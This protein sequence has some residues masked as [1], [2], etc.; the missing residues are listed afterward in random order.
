MAEMDLIPDDFRQGLKKRRLLHNFIT[1]CALVLC[2]VGLV[3][4]LLTYLIWRDKVEV[5]RLEQQESISEQNKA[6]SAEYRQRKEVVQ[7]Q[8]AALD[9]LRGRDRV[10]LFLRAIDAAHSEGIWFDS[11]HFL[12]RSATGTL[13]N[14]PGAAHSGII[15][16]A[17]DAAAAQPLDVSQGVDI[18]GHA[19]N[20]T[21]LADF[22]RKLG[23]Q[24]GVADLRLIDTN[25]RSYTT[26]QVID[27]SLSL[28]LDKKTAARP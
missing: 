6:K 23:E 15:V 3:W 28:Q 12:R 18:V 8:L 4:L 25:L 9:E 7:Q 5:A 10:A 14:V 26:M 24:P 16:A 27:F 19:L 20:H 21:L 11:V 13:G 22:M 2:C 1:A 17:N